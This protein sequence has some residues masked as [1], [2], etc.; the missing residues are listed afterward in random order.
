MTKIRSIH[1]KWN[2][3]KITSP[4]AKSS[5]GSKI[6]YFSNNYFIE[7]KTGKKLHTNKIFNSAHVWDFLYMLPSTSW[8]LIIPQI[9]LKTTKNSWLG[10][11][12]VKSA[13]YE[14]YIAQP[15]LRRVWFG[16]TPNFTIFLE[17]DSTHF[18][19]KQIFFKNRYSVWRADR[20][21]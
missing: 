16:L 10:K 15:I 9:N 20:T 21:L 2:V 18:Q 3:W 4:P 14:Y 5:G 13:D 7:S 6:K 11:T 19:L 12:R 1:K 17:N 8:Q